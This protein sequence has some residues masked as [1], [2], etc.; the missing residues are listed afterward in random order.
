MVRL[1]RHPRQ[2]AEDAPENA[3][4]AASPFEG[5]RKG[6]RLISVLILTKNEERD[7]PHCMHSVEWS[8]DI[9]VFDSLSTDQT[10]QIARSFGAKVSERKFDGYASQRNAA[11]QNLRFTNRWVLI[12]DADERV[13]R[14]LHDELAAFAAD[15]PSDVAACRMRRRDYLGTTWLK[16]SQMS[17]YYIR[18]VRPSRVHYVREVNERLMVDGRIHDLGGHFD[19]FPFSK[20]IDHWFEKHNLYSSME[21]DCWESRGGG[22]RSLSLRKALFHPDFNERRYHQKEL[23]YRLPARPFIKFL[24]LYLVRRGFLDGRAGLT[25]AT[26]QAIYEYM[27]ILKMRESTSQSHVIAEQQNG[28]HHAWP[29]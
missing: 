29:N 3:L 22:A 28:N 18:L 15:A 24:Y 20:G 8:N 13:P 23:F 5:L 19:H 17:P 6:G 1:R 2:K 9:H 10:V 4:A 7:L 27:I 25:Y 12:L 26:L 21:A 14:H 16:H 11:L